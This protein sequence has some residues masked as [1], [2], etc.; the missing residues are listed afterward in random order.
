MRYMKCGTQPASASTQTMRSFGMAL[1][2]AAEHQH[3]H[4]VLAAANDGEERVHARPARRGAVA[5]GEDV[6]RERQAELDRRF[7]ELVVD[8]RVVVLDRRLAGHHHAAQAER[9]D[10]LDV[11]DAFLPASASPSVRR[12]AGAAGALAQYSAI[13]RL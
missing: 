12:R 11:L 6:E 10:R 5:R 1:E 13:Q 4:D 9:L 8:R 3:A 2:D 7:P